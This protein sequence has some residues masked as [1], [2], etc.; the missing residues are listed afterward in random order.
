MLMSW[1]LLPWVT[2]VYSINYSIIIIFI[3]MSLS[4]FIIIIIGWSLNSIFSLMGA[5]RFIARSISYEVRFILI[6]FRVIILRESYSLVDL[7][8]WQLYIW[9]IVILMPIFF[10]F[11]VSILA[12]INRSPMD[13]IKGES[14]LV[15]GFNVEYYGVQVALIFIAEYGR[16]IFFCL[17]TLFLFTNLVLVYLWFYL[18][19]FIYMFY[20]SN[21]NL[22]T[23]DSTSCT[24]RWVNIY[25]LK[26]YVTFNI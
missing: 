16:I 20:N 25:M 2:N 22:Y 13:L 11:F 6:I 5:I 18:Y 21:G 3:L 10:C 4:G 15:S 9:N 19:D 7:R 23:R 12:E 26:N 1:L 14:E 8:I 24:V 17:I